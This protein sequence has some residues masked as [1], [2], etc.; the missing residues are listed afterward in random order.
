MGQPQLSNLRLAGNLSGLRHQHVTVKPR[1]GPVLLFTVIGFADEQVYATDELDNA[2]DGI[3]VRDERQGQ[4][5]ADG[6]KDIIRA[7]DASSN[8]H[9]VPVL[10]SLPGIEW[11]AQLGRAGCQKPPATV[12]L[13]AIAD[14]RH[15]MFQLECF[16]SHAGDG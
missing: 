1:L 12:D 4:A 2:L 9:A 16:D 13:E 5:A 15:S 7:N 10:E 3:R 11:N 6:P 14:A 8:F